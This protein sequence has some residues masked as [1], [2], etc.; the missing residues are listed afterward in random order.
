[1]SG[2][3]GT[4]WEHYKNKQRY[5]VLATAINPNTNERIIVYG[6]PGEHD[7]YWR[8]RTEFVEKFSRV[9]D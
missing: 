7:D 8:S 5:Q 3:I 4:V 2:I 1:M 6:V 9:S